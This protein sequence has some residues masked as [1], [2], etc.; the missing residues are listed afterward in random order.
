MRL[1][2]FA[3]CALALLCTTAIVRAEPEHVR[4]C[5]NWRT[6]EIR[7]LTGPSCPA[8]TTLVIWTMPSAPSSTH[9][10]QGPTGPQGP[11][12]ATGPT[13][14]TGATGNTGATGA[15]GPAGPAGPVGPAGA[16][17]PA[18]PIGATGAAGV[19]GATGA[20]GLTGPM[21]P[22]GLQGSKGDPGPAGP[23]G[24]AATVVDQN[25]VAVGTLTD[26]FGG[27]VMRQAGN[28]S[29][30]FWV[31][32][33]GGLFT[34]PI[35]FYHST[36]D[37]S[38]SRYIGISG[39]S[40][41]AYS[42]YARPGALFYTTTQDPNGLVQVPILAYEHFE[43]TDDATQPGTCV[44]LNAGNASIGVVTTVLDPSLAHLV[45]PLRVQK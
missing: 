38:D 41:F 29:I 43:T 23:S 40:G 13:G 9:A 36:T 1:R 27:S 12:G 16:V 5:V 35:D 25:N 14:P 22:Q 24:T 45:M 20:Q 4:A 6:D 2:T 39:G 7:L 15:T 31:T 42:A 34:S 10:N 8:N 3:G 26:A 11:A 37:C 33:T 30:V 44:P 17:G 21:G 28:D 32:A 19:A 18:G